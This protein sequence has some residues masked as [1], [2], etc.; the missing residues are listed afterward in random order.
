MLHLSKLSLLCALLV[1]PAVIAYEGAGIQREGET[2]PPPKQPQLT[3]AP[4]VAKGVEAAYPTELIQRGGPGGSVKLIIEIG[5]D[6]HVPKATIS[7]SSGI[8]ALD[9]AAL[10][11]IKQFEFTPAE[12]DGQPAAIQ[13][14]YV[15]NF[16]AHPP[17]PPPPPE[18]PP[19]PKP[20]NFSGAVYE[21]GTRDP[22]P[23]ASIYLPQLDLHADCD[24]RGNFELRGVPPGKYAVKI[25]ESTHRQFDTTE[26]FKDGEVV[27]LNAYLWKQI[28]S[29]YETTVRGDREKK[30][31][32]HITLS[33]QELTTVPGTLGDPIRVIQNLPGVLRSPYLS[34]ALLVR[35]AQP[36]DTSVLIDGVPIPL[37]FHFAGGPSVLNPSFIDHIDFY[38]GAYGAKY[39]RAIAGVV[40]V[41]TKP[42]APKAIHGDVAIDLLQSNFYLEGPLVKNKD[43]GTWSIAARRSYLDLLLPSVLKSLQKP[44][45]ATF[46]AA[47][48]YWDYQARYD[49]DIGRNKLEFTVFGSDDVLTLAQAGSAE[50]QGFSIDSHQAF[51][52]A[53]MKW[54][55]NLDSGWNLFVAPSLGTTLVNFDFN[56]QI[57]GNITSVDYNTRAGA[58]KELNRWLKFETG[59]DLN[60]NYYTLSFLLPNTPRYQTFPGE[61]PSLPATQRDFTLHTLSQAVYAEFVANPWRGLKLIPGVRA[62]VYEEVGK[63]MV[64]VEPRLAVRYEF[65]DRTAIKAAWGIYHQPPQPMNLDVQIGNPNLGLSRSEQSV[66]G[67]EQKLFSHLSLDVEGY[68]NWR[69]GLV[70]QSPIVGENY[71]NAGYGKAYGLEVLLKQEVTARMFGWVSYT[72]QRSEQKDVNRNEYLPIIYDQTHLLTVVWS[73][74]FDSGI[75]LG[76]RYR[77]TTGRPTT[78][79]VGATY[80]ADTTNYQAVMG[81]PGSTRTPTFSQLDLRVEKL[82]TFEKWR[83]SAYLDVQNVFNTQNPELIVYDYRFNQSAPV[84]GL[85]FLPTL[86]VTGAF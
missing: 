19:P 73:Y 14:E 11:A 37:L 7:Q 53:R 46:V 52:R 41:G 62:E 26:E 5:A 40:D 71:N 47:P 74:K 30:D 29:G 57:K 18:T 68:Y 36:Q 25:S 60:A 51:H 50:T 43:W 76:A 85:P 83:F 65:N 64:A 59:V 70:V 31:V 33:K 67:F 6:G 23:A 21:R 54:S 69:T 15:F 24:E 2:P 79:Y 66:I 9:E 22:L 81:E 48:R 12:L 58:T 44:G 56:S 32:S 39:G 49:V 8:A 10:V 38:P 55:R 80:D 45:D 75:E 27:Q 63:T 82:W 34:G 35:G 1:S 20:V 61:D 77:L 86:G 84:R 78:P 42:P 3:K 17:P 16:E 13:L 28:E 4:A 72:L